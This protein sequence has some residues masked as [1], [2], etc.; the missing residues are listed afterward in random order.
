MTEPQEAP[1]RR[2][3]KASRTTLPMWA[4]D[5]PERLVYGSNATG[6]WELY[7][8]DRDAGSHT[9]LTD[10][11]EG[12]LEGVIAPAGDSVWWFEDTDGDE[13]GKWVIQGFAEAFDGGPQRPASETLGSAYGMGLSLGRSLAVIGESDDDGSRIQALPIGGQPRL[14]YSNSQAAWMGGLSADE[15]L[16]CFHHAEHGDSRRPALRVVDPQGNLVADL[17]DGPE[18]GLDSAGFSQVAGDE[19]VLVLH[20]RQ[21]SKRPLIW[22]PRTAETKELDLDLPGEVAADWYPDGS[23]L[24][25]SH[26]HAARSSLYRYDLDSG[27]LTQLPTEPGVIAEAAARPDGSV[28]YLWSDSATP[29][30]V[31]STAGEVVLHPEGDVAP[32]GARYSDLWVGKVHT[33]VVEPTSGARPHPTLFHIHGGPEA[34]DRDS[35]SPPVQAWVDHGMAVVM[36]NYRGST[37]Y[38]RDWRDA[39]TGN[40]GFTEREDINA[41]W[42][43]VVAD[44][45]A[46]PKRIALSGNSWG[47]YLT[48]LGLGMDPERWV[49]GIAGVPVADFVAAYEDEKE[50]L[51][52]YDN[53]L[54]AATPQEAPEAYRVRSPITYVENVRAPVMILAGENDPRCPI[55]Q[56]ENYTARLEELGKDHEVLRFDAGHGS[57]RTDERIKQTVAQLEFLARTLGTAPPL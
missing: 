21:G 44:G 36:V 45:I 9:Q 54:F 48:L 56:I 6:K 15:E 1:W 19:R 7:A 37:G 39:I 17:W 13:F 55:R 22:W 38:G 34:H 24:L 23:A 46:D 50:S 28:W 25:I 35:F 51:K 11:R 29:P 4:E 5:A 57:L 14:I 31:R 18:L 42:D 8:W 52:H 20:E 49:T 16:I 27:A 32:P 47:G 26:E 12:T 33:L 10:R 3:F 2:R 30:Q 43:R 53:S 40:P 41:V